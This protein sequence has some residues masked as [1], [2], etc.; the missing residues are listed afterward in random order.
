MP[1]AL[2]PHPSRHTTMPLLL[3]FLLLLRSYPAA[4]SAPSSETVQEAP[5]APPP[6]A[7]TLD[8]VTLNGVEHCGTY[9]GEARFS[10]DHP[11]RHD[12]RFQV[13]ATLHHTLVST[14]A[15]TSGGVHRSP[16]LS[17]LP[18]RAV[19]PGVSTRVTEPGIH[20]LVV[21]I[22]S[23]PATDAA[24]V[25]GGRKTWYNAARFTV[26]D[27]ER[28][29]SEWA[30]PPWTP[31]SP[32]LLR[33]GQPPPLVVAGAGT[34]GPGRGCAEDTEEGG[35]GERERG[36][37]AAEAGGHKSAS[38]RSTESDEGP[39]ARGSTDHGQ[40]HDRTR[41]SSA[42][43]SPTADSADDGGV[44]AWSLEVWAPRIVP[45]GIHFMP[46]GAKVVRSDGGGGGGGGDSSGGQSDGSVGGE[47]DGRDTEHVERTESGDERGG[48]DGERIDRRPHQ[49]QHQRQHR[50]GRVVWRSG[51]V[52]LSMHARRRLD[53]TDQNEQN[54][55]DEAEATTSVDLTV[56]RGY[57]GGV[58]KLDDA[59]FT[60]SSVGSSIGS[61]VGSSVGGD[62]E[63]G[64]GGVTNA[65]LP[66]A[67][68]P[69]REATLR[70]TALL[71]GLPSDNPP[72]SD[73]KA[74]LGPATLLPLSALRIFS[75]DPSLSSSSALPPS[76]SSSS[77][78]PVPPRPHRRVLPSIAPG[79]TVHI[80]AGLTH[81]PAGNVVVPRGAALILDAGCWLAMGE[82]R[83]IVVEGETSP[84]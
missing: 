78:L 34:A 84:R 43:A 32:A 70:M 46:L 65:A 51:R 56:T 16:R 8:P 35:E 18:P 74:P 41:Q 12:P 14:G 4:P 54:G 36:A 38:W 11:W 57:A 75:V 82:G 52:S 49:R 2:A 40:R 9:L 6:P 26:L 20:E 19:L 50:V 48:D 7:L 77:S 63:G 66:H 27:V 1:R 79:Q 45:S 22:I 33:A 62:V 76:S 60:G 23:S 53:R 64:E 13:F 39:G 28:G 30:L 69:R 37:A 68:A 15:F 25:L 29:A 10:F 73:L 59:L 61:S 80:G 5:P 21:G 24:P 42:S 81:A 47:E 58:V 44:G 67:S 31:R 71:H 17:R 3:P 55:V 83:I 72:P